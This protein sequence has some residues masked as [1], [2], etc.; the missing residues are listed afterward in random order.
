V[1]ERPT[2]VPKKTRTLARTQA[3]IGR[4]TYLC[5]AA[6][7]ALVLT[8]VVEFEAPQKVRIDPRANVSVVGEAPAHEF[9][10]TMGA[11]QAVQL[12]ATLRLHAHNDLDIGRPNPEID[13][14]AQLLSQPV[15]TTILGM[16]ATVDQTIRLE[17]GDLEIDVS[18]DATPRLVAKTGRTRAPVL[19]L[20]H[21]IEVVSRRHRLFGRDPT[22]RVHLS[23]RG[24]LARIENGGYRLVF[25]VD[26]HLFS[27]D[28]EVHRTI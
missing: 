25:S 3:W 28:L 1:S 2:T 13:D 24:V 27:L 14:T 21:T 15:V 10:E 19:L 26:E 9:S 8:K 7:A 17:N 16:N 12:R 20:E 4:Y 6:G 11:R 22:R 23:A 18:V 5:I